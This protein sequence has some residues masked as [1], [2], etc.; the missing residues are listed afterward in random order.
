MFEMPVFRINQILAI[1]LIYYKS[2]FAVLIVKKEKFLYFFALFPGWGEEKLVLRQ[3]CLGRQMN[4]LRGDSGGMQ[5]LCGNC[6]CDSEG[7]FVLS[8][9]GSLLWC[10]AAVEMFCDRR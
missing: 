4:S 8:A 10:G 6:L 7:S 3:N 1:L 2:T 9:G 5:F